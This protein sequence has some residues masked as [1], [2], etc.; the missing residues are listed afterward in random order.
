[1]NDPRDPINRAPLTLE[2]LIYR[3]DIKDKIEAYKESK[4]LAAKLKKD[5]I[6]E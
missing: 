3:P 4:K 5:M 2:Q 6:L 1:M